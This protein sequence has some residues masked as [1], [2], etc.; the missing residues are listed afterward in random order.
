MNSK[1][2]KKKKKNTNQMELQDLGV[3][4]GQAGRVLGKTVVRL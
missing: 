1:A 4:S 2:N 3:G